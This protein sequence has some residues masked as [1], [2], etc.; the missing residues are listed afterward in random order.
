MM[1]VRRPSARP[2]TMSYFRK[3]GIFV[4]VPESGRVKTRLTPPLGP[5]GA[6]RLYRAFLA[7]LLP[8]LARIKKVDGTVFYDGDPDPTLSPL[9][10]DRFEMAAQQGADLGR[11]LDRAF[12][13]LLSRDGDIAVIVGSD[14]PDLPLTFVKRAFLKLKH[15]DV[16]LG[17]AFDGGYYLIGIRRRVPGF[18]DGVAWGRETALADTLR[19][20]EALDLTCSILPLWYDVDDSASLSL[21]R[22]MLAGRRIDGRPRLRETETVLDALSME[23]ESK[24]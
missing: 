22:T 9:V 24:P 5:E 7:D 13:H 21:L 23:E 15:R 10:P 19:R 20:V 8:R 14:S 16:V 2:V 1:A 6:A 3:L 12:E 17:P 18:F 11:R 4:K